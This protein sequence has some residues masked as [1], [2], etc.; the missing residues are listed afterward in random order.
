MLATLLTEILGQL[1]SAA[2]PPAALLFTEGQQA[3]SPLPT[4]TLLTAAAKLARCAAA[5]EQAATD[6][7]RQVRPGSK[8][9]EKMFGAAAQ[10]PM[11]APYPLPKVLA[12][13]RQDTT[14]TRAVACSSLLAAHADW[15]RAAAEYDNELTTAK[16]SHRLPHSGAYVDPREFVAWLALQAMPYMLE[17]REC[18]PLWDRWPLPD[19]QT[20]LRLATRA[21]TPKARWLVEIMDLVADGQPLQTLVTSNT[22]SNK[23]IAAR[24]GLLSHYFVASTLVQDSALT[25]QMENRSER[26]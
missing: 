24:A 12:L 13:A 20:F 16:E 2:G 4:A 15:S 6:Y 5:M 17:E 1:G 10:A 3:T 23:N 21:L 9:L 8:A 25:V 22:V 19:V 18:F 14:A 26:R 7:L 11:Q